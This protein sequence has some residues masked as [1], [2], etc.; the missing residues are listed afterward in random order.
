ML[1]CASNFVREIQGIFKMKIS[2]VSGGFDPLHSGHINLLESAA[3]HG[4]KL[5]VLLNS[6]EWLTRKK[7]RPFMPFEERALILERMHMVDYVYGVDDSD[8]TTMPPEGTD[9]ETGT[10]ATPETGTSGGGGSSSNDSSSDAPS[11]EN[12]N[13]KELTIAEL[14][15]LV[16]E[17]SS[18]CTAL[19]KLNPLSRLAV[20]FLTVKQGKK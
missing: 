10:T 15:D 13:Y 8:D 9:E 18:M 17:M 6:D 3:G 19:V 5:V 7:G 16:D 2:V 20:G 4:D 14:K 11:P 12:F 1:K